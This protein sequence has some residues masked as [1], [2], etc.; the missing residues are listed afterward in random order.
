MKMY[1]V[2]SE[3]TTLKKIATTRMLVQYAGASGDFNPLHYEEDFAKNL[4]VGKPIVHGLL[5]KGLAGE[6]D[7][8]LDG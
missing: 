8:R 6:P 5:E 7:D 3:V 4:G 1:E 2:G